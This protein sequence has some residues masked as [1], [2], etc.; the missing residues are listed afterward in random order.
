MKKA[1][2][3]AMLLE[4]IVI[5]IFSFMKKSLFKEKIKKIK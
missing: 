1:K 3:K 2:R 5:C 4:N